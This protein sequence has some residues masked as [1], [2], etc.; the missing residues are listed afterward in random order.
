MAGFTEG[1][2]CWVDAAL[3]DVEAGKRFYGELFGWTFEEGVGGDPYVYASSDGSLVAAL[4]PKKDGRMP[5]VWGVYFAT[6]DAVALSRRIGDAGGQVIT[7]PQPVGTAGRIVVAADPGGAV[8]GLWQAGDEV[9]FE[10]QGE[11][12]SFCWTEVY[13]RDKEAVDP[14]YESVFGFLGTDLPDASV[15][16]RMWSPA[17]TEPGEDT[18]IGGRSVIT[19][20]FPAEMPGHF[21][22]Y[23]CV[24]DCDATA[25]TVTRL[26][27]RVQAPP[28]D[29]PYGRIAVL[30]DNQGASFAVLAEPK[31]ESGPDPA[32]E[33]VS[34][35]E[36]EPEPESEPESESEGE[37]GDE[38]KAA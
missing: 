2:P 11:P 20:A 9:G 25:E 7:E 1:T 12:G 15:D 38:P 35:P 33:P 13:T 17:G 36:Q 23:F 27:G 8:F 21:L 29:I 24:E 18:A 30:A 32:A 28:F 31:S 16:F 34:K 3:P 4:V 6:P 19:D 22:I 37:G 5:T 26:G 14:F 10:K